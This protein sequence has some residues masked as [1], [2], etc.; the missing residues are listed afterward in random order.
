MWHPGLRQFY[1]PRSIYA[2]SLPGDITFIGFNLSPADA[3]GGTTASPEG[4]F[5]V[6]QQHPSGP[7]FG[8]EPTASAAVTQWSDLAWTSFAGTAPSPA[9]RPE[10]TAVLTEPD[11][12]PP[13]APWRL[14][15][16]VFTS[17]LAQ[18]TLP[19][20]LSAAT[21]PRNVQL[22]NTADTQNAWGADAA[23]T[24]YITLRLPFR[25]AIHADLLVPS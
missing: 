20:F 10:A 7:R 6:F 16:S 17:V 2:G 23:Q 21:A 14:S 12:L 4:F 15:S 13:W 1:R 8:L 11:Y 25:I 22:G 19:P 9:S 24:A 5:F 3:K 18:V